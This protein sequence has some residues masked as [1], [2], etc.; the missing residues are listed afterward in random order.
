MIGIA[1]VTVQ[2][3]VGNVTL[4]VCHQKVALVLDRQIVKHVGLIMKVQQETT[5]SLAASTQLIAIVLRIGA[6]LVATSIPELVI[7]IVQVAGVHQLTIAQCAFQ[8]PTC[9]HIKAVFVQK[10]GQETTAKHISDTNAGIHV[11]GK[12]TPAPDQNLKT[13]HRVIEMLTLTTK[14]V[15]VMQTIRP[16]IRARWATARCTL[17]YVRPYVHSVMGRRRPIAWNASGMRFLIEVHVNARK[18][19][20]VMIARMAEG[21]VR[22][23]VRPAKR[24]L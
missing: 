23:R 24:N 3:T 4:V 9:F 1:Y 22:L 21:F 18:A 11:T 19:G 13:V 16:Q 10:A 7:V 2:N 15:Y 6:D 20:V 8:R 17:G 14:N 12:T 5:F